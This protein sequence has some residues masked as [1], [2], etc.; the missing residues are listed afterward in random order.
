[1]T[2]KISYKSVRRL[3]SVCSNGQWP[4]A[5][6]FLA[7]ILRG[8]GVCRQRHKGEQYKYIYTAN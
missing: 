4:F 2:K 5:Q 8:S 1:M 3:S 7:V 6:I